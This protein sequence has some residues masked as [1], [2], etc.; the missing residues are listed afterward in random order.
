MQA[1][2]VVQKEEDQALAKAG[3]IHVQLNPAKF[4][5]AYKA[6]NDGIWETALNSKAT[7]ERAKEFQAFLKQKGF[8][9]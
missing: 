9:N 6:F 7:G 3:V 8:L 5:Q 4:A 1:M 2:D